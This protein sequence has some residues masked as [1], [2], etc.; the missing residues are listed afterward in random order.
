M[1][2]EAA[3]LVAVAGLMLFIHRPLT[4]SELNTVRMRLQVKIEA[5][6]KKID[7]LSQQVQTLDVK[8]DRIDRRFAALEKHFNI[9]QSQDSTVAVKDTIPHK[10]EGPE[11]ER[12]HPS[13]IID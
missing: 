11:E 9:G 12:A 2:K 13:E 5:V 7:R 3:V 10:F 8:I 4:K 6:E 1:R